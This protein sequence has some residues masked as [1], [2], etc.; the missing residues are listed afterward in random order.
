M[1]NTTPT[2]TQVL[3]E[4]YESKE[5]SEV[6]KRLKPEHLQQDIK[7]HVF[8]ELFAKDENFILELHQKNKLKAYIVKILY[9]TATYSRTTFAKELGRETP[10]DFCVEVKYEVL[11]VDTSGF[12]QMEYET[13]IKKKLEESNW[14]PVEL[15]KLYAELGTYKAVSEKTKIPLTSVYKTITEFTKELKK[16]L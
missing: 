8:C 6:L 15:L 11:K 2:A 10:T 13:S 5:V 7:Q 9:N 4:I 1:A 12:E 3:T 14:Y 16:A